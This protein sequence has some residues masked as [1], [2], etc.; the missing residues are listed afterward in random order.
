MF[1][2][3]IPKYPSIGCGD[4]DARN[5]NTA[6]RK[7]PSPAS[8]GGWGQFTISTISAMYLKKGEFLTLPSLYD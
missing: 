4:D 8:L 3:L 6:E 7:Y 2:V 5:G 1:P